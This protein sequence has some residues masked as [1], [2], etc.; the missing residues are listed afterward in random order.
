[1]STTREAIRS[2]YADRAD[3]ARAWHRSGRQVVGYLCDVVPRELISA[4]G[5]LPFR[6]PGDPDVDLD[7]VDEY[8]N[9]FRT[10]FS[11]R[12]TRV[13]F[14]AS[15]LELLLRGSYEFLDYLVV[16]HTRS[17]VQSIYRE[18]TLASE[19]LPP[20]RLPTLY[21]LDKTYADSDG[22]FDR[23]A[24]AE[25]TDV[26]ETWAGHPVTDEQLTVAIAEHNRVRG[27]LS[28]IGHARRAEPPAV[29]GSDALKLF[30]LS[31]ALPASDFIELAEAYLHELAPSSEPDRPRVFLAGS[32][33]DHPAAYELIES[34]GAVV[35]GDDHCWGDRCA[36]WPVSSACAPRD[37]VAER[38]QRM[39]A[40]SLRFPFAVDG[41]ESRLVNARCDGVVFWVLAGDDLQLWETPEQIAAADRLGLPYLHLSGQP[42]GRDV[43]AGVRTQ[44]A[45]FVAGLAERVS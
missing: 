13:G 6:V 45:D 2:T 14:T 22:W 7:M 29:L 9:V 11:E 44:L 16:P 3:A 43:P 20:G 26:L 23:T 37:A 32:P 25:F 42:Y 24:V 8:V 36:E 34:C 4:A 15:T 41:F 12:P 38:F 5:F 17:A 40:C 28:R 1:M 33:H 19:L 18:L 31:T 35:V 39:P 30:S 21:Y 27:V 10:P